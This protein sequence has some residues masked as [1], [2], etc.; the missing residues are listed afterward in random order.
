VAG[1]R[2]RRIEKELDWIEQ[3][4]EKLQDE[5]RQDLRTWESRSSA[6]V[7][8]LD[9]MRVLMEKMSMAEAWLDELTL[10]WLEQC[11]VLDELEED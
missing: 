4:G 6:K 2:R 10:R 7:V 3:E 11:A 9:E 1:K 8:A 5:L